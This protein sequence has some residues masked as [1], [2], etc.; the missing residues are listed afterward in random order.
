[1]FELPGFMHRRLE[2]KVELGA[3]RTE[4]DSDRVRVLCWSASKTSNVSSSQRGKASK[5]ND[6]FR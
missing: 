3:D 5:A 6:T 1:M 4:H 2:S